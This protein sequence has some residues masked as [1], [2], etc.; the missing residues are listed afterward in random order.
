[1]K[2]LLII[3]LVFLSIN[4]ILF[5]QDTLWGEVPVEYVKYVHRDVSHIYLLLDRDTDLVLAKQELDLFAT[6][7]ALVPMSAIRMTKDSS[8]VSF[9]FVCPNEDRW[10]LLLNFKDHRPS[11]LG[12]KLVL[13]ADFDMGLYSQYKIGTQIDKAGLI[14]NKKGIYLLYPIGANSKF[15]RIKYESVIFNY[16]RL[17]DFASNYVFYMT[18]KNKRDIRKL[19]KRYQKSLKK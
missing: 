19:A 14:N 1:M 3:L 4:N 11:N 12:I 13:S 2:K 5:A 6:I 16:Q 10:E 7:W 8:E 18:S 15:T 17:L 9:V